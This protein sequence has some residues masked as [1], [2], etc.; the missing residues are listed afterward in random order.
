MVNRV[1]EEDRRPVVSRLPGYWRML[2]ADPCRG[3]IARRKAAVGKA[4]KRRQLG[5]RR[6]QQPRAALR[7]GIDNRDEVCHGAWV[8]R[9]AAGFNRGRTFVDGTA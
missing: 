8:L 2:S 9:G 6:L 5:G 7:I 1:A 3:E 4:C